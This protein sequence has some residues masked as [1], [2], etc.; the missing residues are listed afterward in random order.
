GRFGLA[1]PR[2]L[3]TGLGGRRPRRRG[4]PVSSKILKP[5]IGA[6]EIAAGFFTGQPALIAAGVATEI[7]AAA[8]LLAPK[9]KPTAST[10]NRLNANLITTAPRSIVF[11]TTAAA[12][13]VRYQA[14][15]GS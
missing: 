3:G 9:A 6:V 14:Y 13:D 12:T 10:Q 11:G 4:G 1:R 8:D 15:S 7:S 2:A 5:I